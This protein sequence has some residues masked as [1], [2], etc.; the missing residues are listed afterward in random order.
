M[1]KNEYSFTYIR[2]V[3]SNLMLIPMCFFVLLLADYF[4]EM[5][6]NVVKAMY[7]L[8]A[9]ILLVLIYNRVSNY[10]FQRKGKISVIDSKKI[11]FMLGTKVTEICISDV[12]K[13]IL[14]INKQ[15]NSNYIEFIIKTKENKRIKILSKRYFNGEDLSDHA[16][17]K[18][19]YDIKNA[20]SKLCFES[21]FDGTFLTL[22]RIKRN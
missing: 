3:Q 17:I 16:F 10:V 6:N 12:E 7:N 8:V 1:N 9:V 15:F 4:E 21:D 18:I 22:E 19:F 13:V 14:S 11:I 2:Y 20:N 5:N